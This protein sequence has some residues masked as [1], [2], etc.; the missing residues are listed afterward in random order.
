MIG[1]RCRIAISCARRIF[2]IVSGHHEPAFTVASLAT[3]T[4]GRPAIRPSPA[5]AP[6]AGPGPTR[7]PPGGRRRQ[8]RDR[9]SRL[10]VA[11]DDQ[12][13]PARAGDRDAAARPYHLPRGLGGREL[14]VSGRRVPRSVRR[15]ADLL[16][17]LHHATLPQGAADR[18]RDGTV[19]RRRGVPAGALRR[20]LHGRGH[21]VHGARGT[22]P[23]E[24]RPG[25][26]GG[27]GIA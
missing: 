25:T 17:Q 3:T 8:R 21:V 2:L 27:R 14:A 11:G 16:L 26:G 24:R 19:H 13:D 18:G 1:T 7:G 5:P 23:G 10:V 22:E 15:G 6:V 9:E 20:N 12:K 4:A